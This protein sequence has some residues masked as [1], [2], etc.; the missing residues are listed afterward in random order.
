MC[1]AWTKAQ[2]EVLTAL[3][4]SGIGVHVPTNVRASPRGKDARDPLPVVIRQYPFGYRHITSTGNII[5]P[6]LP[7]IDE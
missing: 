6:P 3:R 2:R 7:E 1:Q 5:S 4:E